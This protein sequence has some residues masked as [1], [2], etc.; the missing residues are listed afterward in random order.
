MNLMFEFS[1]KTQ[2]CLLEKWSHQHNR[3]EDLIE[4]RS[5]GD[6]YCS[7]CCKRDAGAG[8]KWGFFNLV[9]VDGC[10]QALEHRYPPCSAAY[11]QRFRSN[12]DEGF[13]S[14][15]LK[16]SFKIPSSPTSSSWLMNLMFEFSSKTQ[17]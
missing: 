5:M 14:K 12:S 6:W 3:S 9:S 4:V 8:W 2:S 13:S 15:A 16:A 7:W 10:R 1:S 11:L 17:P